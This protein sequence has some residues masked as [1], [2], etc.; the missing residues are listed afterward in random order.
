MSILDDDRYGRIIEATQ[1]A[2][3]RGIDPTS[4]AMI[5]AICTAVP[6]AS[7]AEIDEALRRHLECDQEV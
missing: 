2:M 1:A 3:E 6:R 5:H 4:Q 7:Q